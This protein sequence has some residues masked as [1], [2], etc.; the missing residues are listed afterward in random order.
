MNNSRSATYG[1]DQRIQ[2]HG[3]LGMGAAENQR[4]ISIEIANKNGS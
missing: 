3:S 1:Y 2:V 4:S